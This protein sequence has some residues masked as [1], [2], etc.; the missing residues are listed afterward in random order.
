MSKHVTI[1]PGEAL[2]R[3]AIRELGGLTHTVLI[4]AMQK[5]RCRF[6][7]STPTSPL[8]CN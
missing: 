7:S 2:D 6:L 8:H 1:A 4:N 5:G 3:L